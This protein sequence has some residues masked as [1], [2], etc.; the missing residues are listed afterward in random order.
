LDL[1]YLDDTQNFLGHGEQSNINIVK[2]GNTTVTVP[3]TIGKIQALKALGSLVQKGS[4]T[5]YVTGLASIG[6][7]VT[8]FEKPFE[9][10]KEFRARDFESLL[11][12]TTIL[13][14]SIN[15]TEKLQQLRGMVDAVRGW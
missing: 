13:G 5:L 2:D 4:I 9:Q 8:S 1:Y 14:T 11:P 7:K 6:V 15:I 10:K 12:V 3:V